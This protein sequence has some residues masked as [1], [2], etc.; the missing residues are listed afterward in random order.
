[1]SVFR[2]TYRGRWFGACTAASLV[3]TLAWAHLPLAEASRPAQDR[4]DAVGKRMYVGTV[5]GLTKEGG[6]NPQVGIVVEGEDVL[7]YVCGKGNEFNQTHSRWLKGKIAENGK[8]EATGDGQ[9][10]SGVL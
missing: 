10:L 5:K 1:M 8:F 9:K 6:P 2:S 3:L 7:A 4:P